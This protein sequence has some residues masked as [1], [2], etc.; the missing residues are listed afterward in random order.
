MGTAVAPV[1][2]TGGSVASDTAIDPIDALDLSSIGEGVEMTSDTELPDSMVIGANKTADP[3][4]ESVAGDRGDGRTDKGQFAK[5][6]SEEPAAPVAPSPFQYR[7]MG[8]THALDGA[9]IDPATGNLT[10]PAAKVA[11]VQEAFNA[12]H[13]A[14]GEYIPVIERH[15]Q[16]SAELRAR[17][18]ELESHVGPKEAQADALVNMLRTAFEEPDDEK[19]L[20][21]LFEMRQR[22]PL[23]LERAKSA[24]LE[25]QLQARAQQP[26]PQ[27]NKT[28]AAPQQA[29]IPSSEAVK[30]TATDFVE[31]L[32]VHPT[33]RD[34]TPEAW[35]A[36]EK[37]IAARP[38]SYT[39][40]A[41]AEDAK[42]FAGIVEGEMV[43]DNDL[44]LAD[45]ELQRDVVKQ[46][47][48]TAESQARLRAANATRT[49]PSIAAPPTPGGGRAPAAKTK[50][51]QTK[52]EL[53]AWYNSDEI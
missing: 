26:A 9:A 28:D 24:H 40:P 43:F 18:Q 1:V 48:E 10:I 22:F 2:E 14:R 32:K 25:K 34:V 44:V 47:R 3:T 53:E 4:D 23:L 16:N 6:E 51:P 31:T 15:R 33:F 13:L 29:A 7:S 17:V 20:G 12:L 36:V 50:T 42:K 30:A 37:A 8:K 35:G 21:A 52:E 49:Q 39:R 5:K 11:D 38:Y 27:P 41:T 45:V 19:A 46:Q